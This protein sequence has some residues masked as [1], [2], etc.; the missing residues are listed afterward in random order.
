MA[1]REEGIVRAF[2]DA[3]VKGDIDQALSYFAD[4]ASYQMNR[5][6]EPFVGSAA[7][8]GDF[9]RQRALWSDLRIELVNVAPPGTSCSPNG[10]T[11]AA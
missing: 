3:C 2:L 1:E 6:H 9:E 10:S 11:P 7:I 4:E 8:R 5:W